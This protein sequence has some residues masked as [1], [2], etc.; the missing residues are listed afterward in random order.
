M[1]LEGDLLTLTL[2][3]FSVR[4]FDRTCP[5]A[6][7]GSTDL[8]VQLTLVNSSFASEECKIQAERGTV[9]YLCCEPGRAS[10]SSKVFD[11]WILR[12]RTGNY[13]SAYRPRRKWRHGATPITPLSVVPLIAFFSVHRTKKKKN[14]A[15]LS[16][17][18][19][20]SS[21]DNFRVVKS[22]V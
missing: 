13:A 14:S 16:L 7:V 17:Q 9:E 6:W 1:C 22:E 11:R 20:R 2:D 3:Y 5:S 19:N 12:P 4:V 15:C 18:L 10:S 21:A 8:R